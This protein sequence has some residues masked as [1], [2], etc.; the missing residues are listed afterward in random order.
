MK[1]TVWLMVLFMLVCALSPA[2]AN[3]W[4]L[5]GDLLELVSDTNEWNEYTCWGEQAG[6]TAVLKTRYHRV[7]ATVSGGKLETYT[8]AV[9]QPEGSY[10]GKP[11]LTSNETGFSL[12]YHDKL[13]FTFAK[14]KE[15]LY[16]QSARAGDVNVKFL[17]KESCTQLTD[18][19]GASAILPRRILLA[20]FNIELFPRTINEARHLN[21]MNAH[22]DSETVF[23]SPLEERLRR[24]G[25]GTA[26]VYSAP[27]G[28]SAWRAA[29][30]KAAVGLNGS[31]EKLHAFRNAD[32]DEYWCIRYHVSPRTQRIGYIDRAYLDG[33]NAAPWEET[34][35]FLNAQVVTIQETWLTD[36]PDVSQYAQ[37]TL[38]ASTVLTCLGLWNH[39][40]AVVSAEVK[41]GRV[42]DGG[43]IVWGF[44]PLRDLQL[45][46]TW[47]TEPDTRLMAQLVG[48]WWFYAGGVSVGDILQLNADC[49]YAVYGY[50]EDHLPHGEPE[51]A[52]QWYVMPHNP[53]SGMY[54]NEPDYEIFFLSDD[55]TARIEGLSFEKDAFSLTNWEG[56]GGYERVR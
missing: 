3:S 25:E 34:T 27:F 19:G 53:A 36:D 22:L 33:K 13:W 41:N 50:A 15:G 31:L 8:R 24:V 5:T 29:K 6:D 12:R 44:V 4:G 18:S 39:D 14:S 17:S 46:T 26:P 51:A 52:G 48:S 43:E 45:L 7:L 16:L 55:G 42:A 38:P 1:R 2:L 30:G 11:Q 32:G 37:F 54:W 56:G 23:S 35:R 47:G 40:Y 10:T 28:Q 49:T 21:Q 9:F 20:D